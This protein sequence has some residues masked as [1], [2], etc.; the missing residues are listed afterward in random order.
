MPI[1]KYMREPTLRA[2][3]RWPRWSWAMP[4]VL[5]VAGVATIA[6][7][8][9]THPVARSPQFTVSGRLARSSWYPQSPG[10]FTLSMT[11]IG[12]PSLSAC[13]S[14]LHRLGYSLTAAELVCQPG[15][16]ALWYH[17][18]LTNRGGYTLVNCTA[19]GYDSGGRLVYQGNLPFQFGGIRG[20]FAS[21]HRI[22][23]FDWYVPGTVAVARYSAHCDANPWP[24]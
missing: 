16:T 17:G 2:R 19:D 9:V 1:L 21:A 20:L 22:T 6:I 5:V 4:G 3:Q 12:A 11:A 8:L 10:Q 23:T 7:V 24:R 15:M 13:A 18:V 14:E